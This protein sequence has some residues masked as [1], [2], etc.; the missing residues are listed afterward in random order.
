MFGIGAQRL[1]GH[2]FSPLIYIVIV[3]TVSISGLKQLHRIAVVQVKDG[4]FFGIVFAIECL[5]VI[6]RNQFVSAL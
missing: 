5:M 6:S 4:Y 3:T 1:C 2:F